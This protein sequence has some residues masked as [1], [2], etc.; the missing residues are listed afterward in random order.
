V[1][2]LCLSASIAA[3]AGCYDPQLASCEVTCGSNSPCPASLT[4]G[5][6]GYCHT[7]DDMQTCG[8]MM[9]TLSVTTQGSGGGK[10]TSSPAGVN[11]VSGNASDCS[12]IPFAV[13]TMIMLTAHPFGDSFDG[14]NGDACNSDP[15]TMCMFTI[16]MP[17]TVNGV[18]N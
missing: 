2:R 6:D 13:G 1:R 17:M 15:Q 18:F 12:N 10:I 5:S 3:I 8:P 11:C 7:S 16:E 4:C 14:W 9:T